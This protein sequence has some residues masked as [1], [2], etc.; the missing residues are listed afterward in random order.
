MQ[1]IVISSTEMH[2]LHGGVKRRGTTIYFIEE[3]QPTNLDLLLNYLFIEN[4]N[5]FHSVAYV[6]FGYWQ[7]QTQ[8]KLSLK[9]PEGTINLL[10]YLPNLIF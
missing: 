2:T 4:K 5:F 8:I 9:N 3:K 6:Y 7:K 10:T 1:F